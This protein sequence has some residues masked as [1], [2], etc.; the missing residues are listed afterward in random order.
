MAVKEDSQTSENRNNKQP[1]SL[2]IGTTGLDA[3]ITCDASVDD[4]GSYIAVIIRDRHQHFIQATVKSCGI[5]LP[6][7]AAAIACLEAVKEWFSMASV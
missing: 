3:I 4:N 6:I 7:E 1:N 5:V 2:K